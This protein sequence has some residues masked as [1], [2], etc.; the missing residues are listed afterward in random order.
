VESDESEGEEEERETEEEEQTVAEHVMPP[1][2]LNTGTVDKDD[3]PTVVTLCENNTDDGAKKVQEEPEEAEVEIEKAAGEKKQENVP[4]KSADE[5]EAE[6]TSPGQ[7]C[8][9]GSGAFLTPGSRIRNKIFP[10]PE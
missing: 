4:E 6:T 5:A 7:C 2:V 8:E 1:A 10:D 3:V 9:S